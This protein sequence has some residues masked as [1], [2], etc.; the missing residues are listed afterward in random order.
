MAYLRIVAA[1]TL[2][3]LSG[4]SSQGEEHTVTYEVSGQETA[5]VAYVNDRAELVKGQVV[6]L[7][8]KHSVK[9]PAGRFV[10]VLTNGAG[11]GA[12]V[13]V[14]KVDGVQ[15]VTQRSGDVPVVRC[16]T[17]IK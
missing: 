1:A 13:C 5:E 12:L 9:V 11:D 15:V 17:T 3:T 14:I 7:P 2:L 10:S 16:D 8:W 4:C 6:A